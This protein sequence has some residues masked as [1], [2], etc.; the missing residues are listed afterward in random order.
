MS[1]RLPPLN[2]FQAF[3]ATARLMSF[4]NAAAELHVTKSAISH[5]IKTLE[6]YLGIKLFDRSS[7]NLTLTKEGQACLPELK[8][9]FDRLEAALDRLTCLEPD[10]SLK[11]NTS[12]SF[13]GKWL[14]PRLGQFEKLYPD[15]EV[16]IST[17]VDIDNLLRGEADVLIRYGPNRYPGLRVEPLP[18]ESIFP[19]ISPSL[20]SGSKP[21]RSPHDLAEHRLIHV[22]NYKR[23]DVYPCWSSWLDTAGVTDINP[24]RGLHYTQMSLA[25]QAAVEGRGV[26][27]VGSIMVDEDLAAGRLSRLFDFDYP[28]IGSSRC[29]CT[30]KACAK[31]P[32]V[33]AFCDWVLKQAAES[34][35]RINMITDVPQRIPSAA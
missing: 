24:I 16:H 23:D 33:E 9:G 34:S 4:T 18:S 3:E 20:L 10:S 26:A 14:M 12:L 11:I 21:L 5:H 32:H 35:E 8:Q 27:L 28:D 1:R 31:L 13:A 25:I 6:H 29:M 7:R 17:A 22:N 30:T 15:I 19:V 2:A